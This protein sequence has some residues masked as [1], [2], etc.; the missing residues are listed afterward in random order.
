MIISRQ[1]N[2][3]IKTR[4]EKDW[5]LYKT[6]KLLYEIVKKYLERLF[7]KDKPKL[8]SNNKNF[9]RTI[10]PYFSETGK[11]SNETMISEKDCIVFDDRRLSKIFNTHLINIT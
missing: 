11:V 7:S 8:I 3:F 2:H 10:R 9:W 1:K 6:K 5:S 4:Y